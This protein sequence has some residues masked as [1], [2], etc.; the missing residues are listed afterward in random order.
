MK[1]EV[2]G[3]IFVCAFACA[4]NAY[5]GAQYLWTGG[6]DGTTLNVGANWNK[7]AA[8]G[9]TDAAQFNTSGTLDLTANADF[10]A[11]CGSFQPKDGPLTVNLDLGSCRWKGNAPSSQ[12]AY[13]F[14][15]GGTAAYPLAV[16]FT[17]GVITNMTGLSVGRSHDG[18]YYGSLNNT[19][20]N[21]SG[22]D[23]VFWADYDTTGVG[24]SGTNNV[25]TVSDGAFFRSGREIRIGNG[26]AASN[27][28]LRVTG[29]GSRLEMRP[30]SNSS[31]IGNGGSFN[32]LLFEDGATATKPTYGNTFLGTGAGA[33]GNR[34][35]IRSGASVAFSAENGNGTFSVGSDG[36]DDNVLAVSNGSFRVTALTLG[37]SA[38]GTDG[39]CG[40]KAYFGDGA[41]G[42]CGNHLYVGDISLCDSNALYAAGTDTLL[43]VTS[44][45]LWL[46]RNGCG[47]QVSV[48]DGAT[49]RINRS[50]NI[51][52]SGDANGAT[53]GTGFGNVLNVSG[54]GTILQA[55][56]N[57]TGYFHLG[58]T[59]N[60]VAATDGGC[61]CV[62]THA[63][64]GAGADSWS[65]RLSV[66]DSRLG[67]S[68]QMSVGGW[69]GS[70][71]NCVDIT[72]QD[73]SAYIRCGLTIGGGAG[74]NSNL[75]FIADG[76][77]VTSAV[78]TTWDCK[79]RVGYNATAV[80]NRMVV[81][82]ATF[83]TG[84]KDELVVNGS[85]CGNAL[86][87]VDGAKVIVGH[88]FRCGSDASSCYGLIRAAGE[89]TVLTNTQYHL[90]VNGHH[91][92]VSIEDGAKMFIKSTM[93]FGASGAAHSNNFLRIVNGGFFNYGSE[94]LKLQNKAKLIWKG[95]KSQIRVASF[96]M[97]NDGE[98]EMKADKD[99][100]AAFGPEYQTY[101]L[102]N[103]WT[104][105]VK[106][107]TVDVSEYLKENRK[108][109]FTIMKSGQ[110]RSCRTIGS[111]EL[112]AQSAETIAAVNKAFADRIEFIPD[113]CGKVES[114][115]MTKSKIVVSV[116]KRM[117][118]A[119]I[120]R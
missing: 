21:I 6:G 82:N 23:T 44:Y 19:A 55:M 40:N 54:K 65:N 8:P 77:V 107:I 12:W 89:G 22:M 116:K 15:T 90:T 61:V 99:G 31:Y 41:Q 43:A 110:N 66:V 57:G 1:K 4:A 25:L 100:L 47:N 73:A 114:V 68:N 112:S 36:S 115:D 34:V 32:E 102:N 37:N 52:S 91:N 88:S 78:Y 42:V 20:F 17:G 92:G 80:G 109:V 72:G 87:A 62:G 18:G 2:L 81:S 29:K 10:L 117:G 97:L 46:G 45:D 96:A 67:V 56:G 69:A 103:D 84:T 104:P 79:A 9:A 7:D 74:A 38:S 48:S 5:T 11:G 85:G 71:F 70:S 53:C 108:G 51:G 120:V 63:R 76:A 75:V 83:Y 101:L 119:L 105:S 28:L 58:G 16:N 24:Y 111:T 26:E 49:L 59:N 3:L 60:T 86:E 113:G 35:T 64:I 33:H 39:A 98:I 13:R 27:N 95:A 93:D 106:K 30:D 118:M 14:V 94:T 50:V